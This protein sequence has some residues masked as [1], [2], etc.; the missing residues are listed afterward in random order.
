MNLFIAAEHQRFTGSSICGAAIDSFANQHPAPPTESPETRIDN[1][2]TPSRIQGPSD[3]V[4]ER[5][6]EYNENISMFPCWVGAV[7]LG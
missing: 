7:C 6:N 2:K 1:A 4:I 5:D 3:A